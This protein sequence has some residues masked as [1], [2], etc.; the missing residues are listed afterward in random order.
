VSRRLR[1]LAFLGL[2][3]SG[4]VAVWPG[5]ARAAIGGSGGQAHGGSDTG[6]ITAS[7][8]TATAGVISSASGSSCTWRI[9]NGTVGVP[10]LGTLTW[11]HEV[12]GVIHN[13][14]A[15]TCPDG[16]TYYSIAETRPEDLLPGLLSQ[17][18]QRTLPRPAP[19]FELLDP[20]F[21]WAYVQTPL[22]FRAGEAWR[23]VSVTASVGSVW[24]TVTATPERLVFDPGDP[25][26]PGPV[27]CAGAA[28]L[29]PYVPEVPGAC[30]YT[31]RNASST[32][33]ADGYHFRTRL[34][35]EWSISWT[36]STGAGGPLE[37]YSTSAE[38]LLAVAEVKG[39]VTCTGPRP[40]QGGC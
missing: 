18:Q 36:S 39:L 2:V 13:L 17:L 37:P 29:A 11:P 12:D 20:E 32:S 26:G 14:W 27:A 3:A 8:T 15:R 4:W 25:A 35:I 7:V 34:T 24:A 5:T 40:E 23:P 30:S 38:A 9:E 33:P 1:L 19:T 16:V 10:N 22:D 28:P 6:V 31:Y 21:G